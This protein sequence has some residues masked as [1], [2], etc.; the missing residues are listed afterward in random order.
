MQKNFFIERYAD[1]GWEYKHVDPLHAIRVNTLIVKEKELIERLNNRGVELEKAK[2]IQHG[3]FITK[4]PFPLTS[5]LEYLKGYFFFQDA[6]AQKAAEL[7]NPKKEELV[8][9]MCASPGGK[10]CHLAQLMENT[11]NIVA[12][13][14][15]KERLIPLKNNLERCQIKNTIVYNINAKQ[16]VHFKILFDKILLDAPCSGN[17]TQERDWFKKRDIDGIKRNADLQKELLQTAFYC[18][19]TNGELVYATCSLE[20]EEN[21]ENCAWF[22][23]KF[24]VKMVSFER[25]W[26]EQTTGFFMAKFKKIG[27]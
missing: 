13:E 12:L 22:Q 17:F 1:L 4:T 14:L 19:K 3:F 16:A 20:P 11:G 27:V 5:S 10:T 25:V 21:E 7:L 2:G 8:L 15:K 6:A 18:L 9:D 26:P 24:P 23:K